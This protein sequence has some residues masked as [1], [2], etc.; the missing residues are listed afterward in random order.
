[1]TLWHDHTSVTGQKRNSGLVA[2]RRREGINDFSIDDSN[3]YIQSLNHT[4]G[5]NPFITHS[6]NFST[7]P[8][9]FIENMDIDNDLSLIHI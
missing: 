2:E 5:S 8:F 1:M 4:T 3:V 9:N 7:S 6:F